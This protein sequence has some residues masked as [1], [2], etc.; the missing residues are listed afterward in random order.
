MYD[1]LIRG[2]TVLDPGQG[3]SGQL[4]IG[5]RGDQIA[6]IQPDISTDEASQVLDA[7]D[8]LVTPGL[9][10]LHAHV[11]W[12]FSSLSVDPDVEAVKGAVT[13]HVDA[14]TVDA[15]AMPGFRRFII[16]A[17]DSRVFVFLR[18]PWQQRRWDA[19][20]DPRNV[21]QSF[22]GEAERAIEEHADVVL[23]LK[24][25][26]GW[27]VAGPATEANMIYAREV[28][29]RL[30]VPIMV[31]ISTSPPDVDWVVGLLREGDILSHC[32]TGHDQKIVDMHGKL[33]PAVKEAR[34]RG[35]LLDIGHGGG[36][37]SFKV[38][39]Q[40]LDQGEPP[41]VI[42]TDLHIGSVNGPVWTLVATLNKFLA[43]GMSVEDVIERATAIPARAINR[44]EGLGALQVGGVADVS[45]L[46]YEE[47]PFELVDCH[48]V[49]KT[50]EKGLAPDKAIC[51]GKV[52][53]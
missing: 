4:D 9:I 11:A 41:D 7:S 19:P 16:D 21:L 6:A 3:L 12:G 29:D 14:G 32:F 49:V 42:S 26:A 1:L 33:L 34:E 31:H 38:A 51:R 27:N 13:T 47:G 39:E 53:E 18:I 30:E 22:R 20:Q 25:Y 8:K 43:L 35:V 37:F 10:D 24:A 36:S 45:L 17:F 52:L 2:G 28:A 5:I 40:M 50:L 15:S 23:G 48:R 46:R 44:L